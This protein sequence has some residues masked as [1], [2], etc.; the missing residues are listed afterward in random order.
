MPPINVMKEP[1]HCPDAL[2]AIQHTK[3][4]AGA[5]AETPEKERQKIQSIYIRLRFWIITTKEKGK[6]KRRCKVLNTRITFGVTYEWW[7]TK[8]SGVSVDVDDG[9]PHFTHQ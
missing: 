1:E 4:W 2:G 5:P 3:L 9:K 6:F 8:Y 7:N